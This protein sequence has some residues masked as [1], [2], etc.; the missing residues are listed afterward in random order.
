MPTTF[1]AVIQLFLFEEVEYHRT[2]SIFWP[3]YGTLG[4]DRAIWSIC[5]IPYREESEFESGQMLIN[6][7][8][9]WK[10]LA[11]TFWFNEHS[12]F[13]YSHIHGDKET[14]AGVRSFL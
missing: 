14:F 10:P 2:G 11:L 5:D 8:M 7:T 6:K 3:D 4:P 9:C 12:D 1:L 13:F